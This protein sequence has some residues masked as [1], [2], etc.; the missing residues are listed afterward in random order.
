MTW[1]VGGVITYS[2]LWYGVPL[3]KDHVKI[4]KNW[5]IGIDDV[6]EGVRDYDVSVIK[7]VSEYY[8]KKKEEG[9]IID[10]K[11]TLDKF[12]DIKE[13]SLKKDKK[14]E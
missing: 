7:D 14:D 6:E 12:Q 8:E 4:V 13:A 11:D 10:Y 1:I 9:V 3:I 5:I 2:S